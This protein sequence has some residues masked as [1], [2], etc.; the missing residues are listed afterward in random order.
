MMFEVFTIFVPAYQVIR[1]RVQRRRAAGSDIRWDAA[2]QTTTLRPVASSCSTCRR[3]VTAS[4]AEKGQGGGFC[5]IDVGEEGPDDGRLLTMSALEQALREDQG[6]LQEFSALCDFSGENIAFL[7]RVAT[8]KSSTTCPRPLSASGSLGCAPPLSPFGGGEEKLS[9]YNAALGLYADFVSPRLAEFPLNL[10]SDELRRLEAV[11]EKSARI[12]FGDENGDANTIT[13]FDDGYVA[14]SGSG[15]RQ[16]VRGRAR[17]TGE[18]PAGFGPDVFD[19][20]QRQVKYLVLTN[21]WPRFVREM[22]RRSGE[23]GRSVRTAGSQTSLLSK[24]STTVS[25]LIRSVF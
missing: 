16:D 3:A 22:R 24:V 23:T 12:L 13:P 6:P 2:S 9:A 25:G 7:G 5:R 14:G 11:F 21:T 19:D 17:Y 1:L 10:A 15:R 18:V 4:T 8:W 20:A